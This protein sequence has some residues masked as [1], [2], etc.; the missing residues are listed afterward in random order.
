M[1]GS[2]KWFSYQADSGQ[3]Y[4]VLNDESK[5]EATLSTGG[6]ALSTVFGGIT[7]IPRGITPRYVNAHDTTNPARR[8]RFKISTIA[9]YANITSATEILEAAGD[10]TTATTW[11]VTSKRGETSRLPGSGDTG[12]LDGD[13][14]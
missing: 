3:T 14:P 6:S 12:L 5:G 7:D 8:A 13:N 1:A 10:G 2:L 11:K 4:A 9:N